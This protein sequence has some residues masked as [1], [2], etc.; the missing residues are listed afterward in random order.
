[1]AAQLQKIDTT[2]TQ[3]AVPQQLTREQ[4]ELVKRT[5][6]KGATD[7]ELQMFLYLARKY[8]LDPFKKEIWFVKRG[9]D[10]TI[11]TSRDGYLKI[12]MQDPDYDGLMAGV[13]REGDHFE[14]DAA[15]CTV[16]HRFGAKR[17]KIIGAWAIAYHKRRRPIACFVDF[18]EY[19][20]DSPTWRKYPSAMI[21]KVAE[22]FVLRRQFAIS[23]LVTQEEIG[24]GE[25][26]GAGAVE[27]RSERPAIG[28]SDSTQA[29]PQQLK[30]L[31]ASAQEA[32]FTT[33]EMREILQT[34]Y[35]VQSSKELTREQASELIDTLKNAPETLRQLLKK[36][37]EVV[38]AD[39]IDE[40][41]KDEDSPDQL[42]EDVYDDDLPFE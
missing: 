33:D 5:V 22:V 38:D 31:F 28:R 41:L 19:K 36:D 8:D 18:E 29:T 6:A 34:R 30:A 11:M 7:D 25:E 20:Q 21:Q 40:L 3:A 10:A 37:S 16:V 23:G 26:T 4:I 2:A 32:G 14:F 13:V 39:V 24:M 17:G 12:A 9:G 27:S 15:N 35:G 1:M 42:V